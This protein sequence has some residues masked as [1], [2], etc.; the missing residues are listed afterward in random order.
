[1]TPS[2]VPEDDHLQ[3]WVVATTSAM[4]GLALLAVILR[5]LSRYERKQKLWWDD[6]MIVFSMVHLLWDKSTCR[7]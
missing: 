7:A 5:L 6:W 1:M 4:T 3:K 2:A